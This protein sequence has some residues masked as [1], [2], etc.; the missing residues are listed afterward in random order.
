MAYID[1]TIDKLLPNKL[2]ENVFSGA[3]TFVGIDFGTS[4][5]VISVA[6]M[7]ADSRKIGSKTLWIPQ[8]SAD[9]TEIKSGICPSVIAA[10]NN[11]ILVGQGAADLKF[12][13]KRNR[14]VWYSFKMDL[15]E[16][17]GSSFSE[18]ILNTDNEWR[19]LNGKDAARVFF[20]YLKLKIDDLIL[21]E[22]WSTN[23]QYAVSIPASFEAN[24]R[25]DLIECLDANGMHVNS[26]AL[27]DEPNAAFISYVWESTQ[28]NKPVKIP[29]YNS[30]ILVFD[31][32]AGTCD[33]S[34]LELGAVK[35]EVYSKNLSISKFEKLGGD[36]VDRMIAFEVLMPQL[37]EQNK[38]TAQN[39]RTKVI[40]NTILPKLLKTAESL[41]VQVCKGV[42][43][44]SY[45]FELPEEAE[46]DLIIDLDITID[47][48]VGDKVLT[49][50]RPKMTYAQFNRLMQKF[51]STRGFRFNSGVYHQDGSTS[52]F[53]PIESALKKANLLKDDIDNV[54]L[55][56]GSSKNPYIQKALKDYFGQADIL[57]PS[58]T[59]LQVSRGAAIHSL[60]L[61]GLGKNIIKPIT[62]EPI[63]VITRDEIPKILID[64]STEI[65]TELAHFEDLYIDRDNQTLLELPICIGNSN[66]LLFNVKISPESGSFNR[67]D[68]VSLSVEIS[69]DKILYIRAS[70]GGQ[71]IMVTPMNPFSNKEL[72]TVERMILEAEKEYNNEIARLKGADSEN[73]LRKL[74]RVYRD[75]DEELKSAETLEEI[76]EKFPGNHDYN[77]IG[78]HYSSAGNTNKA[79]EYYEKAFQY[80][81]SGTTAFNSGYLLAYRDPEKFVK[82]MEE[83]IK[84]EN[85]HAHALFE[86]GKYKIAH[87]ENEE[88]EKMVNQAFEIWKQR[89]ETQS[90]ND[91]EYGW[92]SSC[93]HYL[94]E[95]DLAREVS[96]AKPKRQIEKGYNAQNLAANKD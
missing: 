55:I 71:Q 21:S 69:A 46:S 70:V 15:G 26:Q 17:R 67:G 62:S 3:Y 81:P 19:I 2:S 14:D 22:G 37:F 34:I 41:K 83:A 24:Q 38:V 52:I 1:L 25:K 48:P 84:L 53:L 29:D 73:A 28:N 87:D 75:K 36:D 91:G 58:D 92:L 42:S 90:L 31:F 43:I 50:K 23:I 94:G 65:P 39:F 96:N 59:Q 40:S 77:Q 88:G 18:S 66:K 56:G 44:L 64:P 51:T 20:K 9:G 79:I 60:V 74:Y 33:I 45:G 47:I 76:N 54:L 12:D 61:N 80:S 89:Y 13:L 16:D 49:L 78:L 72:S 8:K 27:I 7:S 6:S 30:N 68:K 95:H 82:Y 85:D 63:L 57:I 93:A 4:T 11:T 32:G 86:L 5:T 10:V 35:N